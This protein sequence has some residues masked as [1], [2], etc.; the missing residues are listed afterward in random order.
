MIMEQGTFNFDKPQPHDLFKSGS[1][2]YMIYEGL[3]AGEL[4]N[5]EIQ[6]MFVLSHTRRIADIREK[7]KPYLM[8]IKKT[9]LR[10][11]IYSYSLTGLNQ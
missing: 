5:V 4:T 2:C 1:Q 9:R 3:L 11:G 7:L 6:K 8:G 10:G